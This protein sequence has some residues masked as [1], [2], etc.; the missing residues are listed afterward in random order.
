MKKCAVEYFDFYLLHNVYEKSME[1]YLDSRWGIVDYFKEQKRPG[2]IRHLGFS[3]HA[4]TKG[5][6][7]FLDACGADMEFMPEEKKPSACIGCGKW[8]QSCPQNID[9]PGAMKDFS[10][11]LSRLPSWAEICRQREAAANKGRAD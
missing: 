1:T 7:Q 4:E 3:C 9:I 2:R 6:K 5:V 8:A 10:E 11:K